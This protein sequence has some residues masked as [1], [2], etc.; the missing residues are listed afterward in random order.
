LSPS[1]FAQL[2][3]G[4]ALVRSYSKCNG[5]WSSEGTGFLVGSRVVMTAYHVVRDACKVRVL[6]GGKWV[7]VSDSVFWHKPGRSDGVAADVATVKLD[8]EVE[9]HAFTIR[10][11][12]A[13]KGANLSALGHPLGSNISLTQGHVI[14]KLAY[15]GIPLLAVRLLGAEGSSGSPFVDDK[16]NVVGILQYGLGSKDVIG[17]YTS[18]VV[19]G[20]D[21]ASWWSGA[22]RKSLCRYYRN[23]GIPGCAGST[24][25]P[26]L[27]RHL[28]PPRRHPH[29]L[30]PVIATTLGRSGF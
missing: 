24:T 29:R 12:S 10:T 13:A 28:R 1:L 20:I 27:P 4:I 22:T 21:L 16:G 2:S 6:V 5:S 19:E 23:G 26:Q 3:T 8:A 11:W 30:R 9:G 18:G 15:R 7:G 25:P 17:Q 14:A